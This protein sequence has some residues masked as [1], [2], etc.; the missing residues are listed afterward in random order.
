MCVTTS[1]ADNNGVLFKV[2]LIVKPCI[3]QRSEGHYLQQHDPSFQYNQVKLILKH[4][5]IVVVSFQRYIYQAFLST[6]PITMLPH[7]FH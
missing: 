4:F 6:N 2:Y 5:Y 3:E 7:N 1:A